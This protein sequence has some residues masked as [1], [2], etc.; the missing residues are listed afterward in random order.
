VKSYL[1]DLPGVLEAAIGGASP[2]AMQKAPPGKWNSTQILEHLYLSYTATNQ[3]IARRLNSGKP[4]VKAA[5]LKQRLAI[6]LVIGLGYFPEGVKAPEV[7]V[8][9]GVPPELVRGTIFAEIQ[10][11]AAGLDD[12]ERRFGRSTKIVNHPILGP[13][14]VNQCRKLHWLHARHHARQIRQR[15]N[16]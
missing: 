11:M 5:T 6:F 10:K 2:E 16:L 13:L 7:T 4:V 9:R 15:T 12:C 14:S 8:P 1:K 3:A